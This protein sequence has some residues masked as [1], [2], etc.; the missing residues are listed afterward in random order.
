MLSINCFGI[1]TQRD[2]QL[3][4]FKY[5][6]FCLVNILFNAIILHKFIQKST[7]FC[8]TTLDHYVS[9]FIWYFIL[10]CPKKKSH[11]FAAWFSCTHGC[12]PPFLCVCD[13]FPIIAAPLICK[14]NFR[15]DLGRESK[16]SSAKIVVSQQS[17]WQ[18]L[19]ELTEGETFVNI[20]ILRLLSADQVSP[21]PWNNKKLFARVFLCAAN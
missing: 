17:E 18:L 11:I 12:F 9:Y 7:I 4:L 19:A 20:N 14:T 16:F 6:M 5:F 10:V 21:V 1:K 15:C 2:Y 8:S 3:L 13:V